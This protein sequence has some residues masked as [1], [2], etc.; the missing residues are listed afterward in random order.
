MN[1]QYKEGFFAEIKGFLEN[2]VEH[3]AAFVVIYFGDE[4]GLIITPKDIVSLRM[5][6]EFIV[7]TWSE[8]HVRKNS[9]TR[10]RFAAITRV[11]LSPA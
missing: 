3:K 7:V 10:I 1:G 9:E 11:D 5:D 4:H 8:K 6:E 2:H